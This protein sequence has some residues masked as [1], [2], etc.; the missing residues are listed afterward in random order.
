ML[1][2]PLLSFSCFGLCML[3]A[4]G[5]V[6]WWP[7]LKLARNGVDYLCEQV[8]LVLQPSSGLFGIMGITRFRV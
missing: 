2:F 7:V 3:H 4:S 5:L 6:S 1:P 8:R